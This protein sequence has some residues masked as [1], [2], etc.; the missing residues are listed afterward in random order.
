M[1]PKKSLKKLRPGKDA[2]LQNVGE[3]IKFYNVEKEL[4][5]IQFDAKEKIIAR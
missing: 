3:K 4:F 5:K 1:P 2:T